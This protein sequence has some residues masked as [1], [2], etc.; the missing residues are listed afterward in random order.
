MGICKNS[1]G[2]W[3]LELGPAAP[4]IITW[5]LGN[6]DDIIVTKGMEPPSPMN[7]ASFPK[8]DSDDSLITFPGQL[9]R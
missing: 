9:S 1:F 4:V 7:T 5:A 2:P 3:G 8:K 6:I